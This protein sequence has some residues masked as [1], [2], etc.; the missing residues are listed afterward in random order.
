M[1]ISF[2]RPQP[3]APRWPHPRHWLPAF[4]AG[5]VLLALFCFNAVGAQSGADVAN[6]ERNVKAAFLVKFLGYVD[7][8]ENAAP[9]AGEPLVIGVLGD[10]AVAEELSRITA[11]RGM[12]GRQVA[13]RKLR[14]GEAPGKLHLL[15]IG[16]DDAAGIER[17][18][19]SVRQ[20]PVLTVT[21]TGRNLRLDSVINFRVIDERV[22]FEVS[23]EAAEKSNLKLSSRLLAVAYKVQ[24]AG[25]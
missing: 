19:A 8:P 13:V 12:N 10:D 11:G 1:A 5:A 15:F 16:D 18:L 22:R 17:A 24:R 3:F 2:S 7:F 6:L 9:T 14:Q 20:Q 4:V 21:E 25:H 23:L